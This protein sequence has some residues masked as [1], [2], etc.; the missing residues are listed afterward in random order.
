M[1]S[2]STHL[3]ELPRKILI[4]DNVICQLGS[5]IMDLDGKASKIAIITGNNV[6]AKVEKVF[7]SSVF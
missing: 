5:F 4:G 6:K 2:P 3:M 1:S 7:R